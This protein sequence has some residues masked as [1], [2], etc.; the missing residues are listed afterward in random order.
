[1]QVMK[2]LLLLWVLGQREAAPGCRWE[3]WEDQELGLRMTVQK[4]DGP[5]ARQFKTLANTVRLVAPGQ[6]PAR[7]RIVIAVL[8]KGGRQK[9][10][11]AILSAVGSDFSSRQ[12]VGC[13][14]VPADSRFPLGDEGKQVWQIVPNA[15]YRAEAERLRQAEPDAEVCGPYGDLPAAQYFEYHPAESKVRYLFVR[16]GE[17]AQYFDTKSIVLTKK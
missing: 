14:V 3:P 15:I 16:A 17:Y 4:C 1:M 5:S 12:K 2:W 7:A 10:S 6:D 8:D 11:D 13:E 9:L